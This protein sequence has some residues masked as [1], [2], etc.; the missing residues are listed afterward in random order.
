MKNPIFWTSL[1][2]HIIL[3]HELKAQPRR[4]NII[5]IMADDLGFEC[6]GANG[7]T[8]YETPNI[9][10]LAADGMRFEHCHA[11]PVC[12]PSRVQLMTGQ[13]NFRNYTRFA[14]LDRGQLSFG[15]L[16]K[17]AG[18][19]TAI[20]GKWQLGMENDSPQH[21]GFEESC[22]WRQSQKRQDANGHDTRFQNPTLEINGLV[23][24]FRNGEFGPDI[25]SDFLIKFMEQNK[26]HPF[27]VYYPMLLAHCPF[28]PM[29]GSID[30]DPESLGS[31]SYKGNSKYFKGMVGYMD[32][33]IGRIVS[34]VENMGIGDQTVIIFTGDNGTDQP[35]I[36]MHRG[37]EYPGGKKK[38][39][40]NGTHV[41]LIVRWDGVVNEGSE[42]FNL[43]DF[44][45][46]LPTLCELAGIE[47]PTDIPID[48]VSFSPQLYGKSKNPRKWIYN[49]YSIHNKP[50]QLK[51]FVRTSQYKLYASGEFYNIEKDFFEEN[52]LP[53]KTL[54]KKQ[55]KVYGSLMKVI[56]DYLEV[57]K[58][59]DK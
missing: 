14:H 57:I 55:S 37:R 18:Y 53:I 48:G 39:T 24:K 29:P 11:L 12:T 10:R 31:L 32:K 6:I 8:S 38:T 26:D 1:I 23:K 21:F 3:L 28:V 20:A 33:I 27:F 22:L 42:N 30:W 58:E 59:S 4:P 47:L 9:D 7:G 43:I 36:S 5:L 19:K 44:S 15:N 41:P 50:K 17:D 25:V 45:D 16:L 56:N 40:D 35:I 51:Q 54:N 52:P 2:C 34:A 46:F 13:Y 49:W